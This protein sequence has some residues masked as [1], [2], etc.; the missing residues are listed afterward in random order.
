M[1]EEI[2]DLLRRALREDIGRGDVTTE[3]LIP[4]HQRGEAVIVAKERGI[5]CGGTVAQEIFKLR[6][7]SLKIRLDAKD[8]SR[9]RKG[10]TV[11]AVRGRIRPILE[12]ERV[13]L[14]FLGRLSGIATLTRTF[15]DRIRGTKA[16]ILDT[17]KTTP[18]WRGLEKYAVRCGGG[19]NHRSGLWDE[20]L[21]KDNH[22]AAIMSTPSL[23]GGRQADEAIKN[24][25][26]LRA[27]RALAMT[28]KSRR[29]PIEVEVQSLK[30]LAHL[31][32][33][34][35]V[36]DR[37]LLDNFTIKELRRAILFVNGLRRKKPLL[38]A[39]GGIHLTNIRQVA[40]TGVDRISIGRLTHSAPAIDFSL[41]IKKVM[42]A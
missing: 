13:A 9:I 35:L 8:G 39:S 7:A 28:K 6:D 1:T 38:E 41:K 37:I 42:N 17:R 32:E 40:S 3:A 26:L 27:L 19:E 21:V 31:A 25:R 30:E 15:V 24:S 4:R 5:F 34:T 18:L 2:R 23:R 22:W 12:A 11:L 14:N 36:P 33:G 29:I 16:K 20:V 10:Q